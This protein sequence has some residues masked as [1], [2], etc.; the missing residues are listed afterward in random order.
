MKW[1]YKLKTG[2]RLRK[3]I[4]SEDL[5]D[6]LFALRL[7]YDELVDAGFISEDDYEYYTENFDMYDEE[8][9]DSVDFE[10]NEFYDLCDNLR[11]WVEI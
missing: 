3:A 6:T 11:V 9:V 2:S 10:L 1:D 5:Y 8:D 7:C 4:E